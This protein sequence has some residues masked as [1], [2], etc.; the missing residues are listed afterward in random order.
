MPPTRHHPAHDDRAAHRPDVAVRLRR[1]G[2]PVLR[3]GSWLDLSPVVAAHTHADDLHL[4]SHQNGMHA[5]LR[6]QP[7]RD[8]APV[9]TTWSADRRDRSRWTSRGGADRG[10]LR[11]AGHRAAARHRARAADHGCRA[12]TLTPF[13]GTYFFTRP[14]RRRARLHRLRDRPPLPGHRAARRLCRRRVARRSGAAT[15][16][17]WCWAATAQPGRSKPSRRPRSRPRSPPPSTFDEVVADSAADVRRLRSRTIAPWR[18]AEHPG[19]RTR[20]LRAVVGDRRAGGFR[21]PASRC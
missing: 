17:R 9:D 15:A 2:D 14:G 19:R 4:V 12:A 6:L 3:R 20:R 8:G 16:A 13:T 11:P 7:E 10:R 5:V 1:P 18:D 21:H